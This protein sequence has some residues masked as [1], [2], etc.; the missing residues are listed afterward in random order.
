M[1]RILRKHGIF[2]RVAAKKISIKE[3]SAAS[4]KKWSQKMIEKS[5]E[6]WYSVVFTDE[7]RVK[8]TSDG[9][10]ELFVFCAK[11]HSLC[12]KKRQKCDN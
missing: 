5:A 7:T 11:K 4:R 6:N 8:L 12:A 2:S 1:R 3:T 9:M 10:T